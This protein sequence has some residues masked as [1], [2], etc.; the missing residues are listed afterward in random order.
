MKYYFCLIPAD[1]AKGANVG[2]RFAYEHKEL[3]VE[4]TS[5][6]TYLTTGYVKGVDYVTKDGK[7]YLLMKTYLD[8]DNNQAVIVAT[9]STYGCDQ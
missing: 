1:K 9:E 8:L 7:A 4:G 3:W 5:L 6:S 2:R